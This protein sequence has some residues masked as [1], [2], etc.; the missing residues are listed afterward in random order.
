VSGFRC[1]RTEDRRQ[2]SENRKRRA[3]DISQ[4]IVGIGEMTANGCLKADPS[5]SLKGGTI[6]RQACG[7]L[8]AAPGSHTA[9]VRNVVEGLCKPADGSRRQRQKVKDKQ[10]D[11]VTINRWD[12]QSVFCNL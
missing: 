10:S 4:S 9:G 5:S 8:N 3:E 7:R 12:L 1:Q 11:A 2:R 6:P